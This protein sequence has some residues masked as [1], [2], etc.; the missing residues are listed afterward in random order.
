MTETNVR[1]LTWSDPHATRDRMAQ[2][3]GIE[4]MRAWR[5]GII[6]PAPIAE[7]MGFTLVDVAPGTV[8]FECRPGPE[9][10]NPIGVVHGG[11]ACTLL[12]SATGCAAHST[13]EAGM[14]Y[15]SIEISVKYLRPISSDGGVLRAVGTVTKAGGRVIFAEATLSDEL[16]RLVATASSTLLVL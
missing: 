16:G 11:L 13:L 1:T 8:T 14:G 15:T 6:P 5:D 12:D 10:Y 9:L 2:L 3:S 7:T 4:A